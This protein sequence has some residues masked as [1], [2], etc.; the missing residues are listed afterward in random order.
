MYSFFKTHNAIL[1]SNQKIKPQEI[2]TFYSQLTTKANHQM[3]TIKV[4]IQEQRNAEE[5]ERLRQIQLKMEAER[6]AKEEEER[7][8]R[9]EEENRRKKVIEI[10]NLMIRN[11]LFKCLTKTCM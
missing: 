6:K 5:Q 7:R 8:L 11:Y 1:Q 3:N 9:E 4:K 2:D 10:K